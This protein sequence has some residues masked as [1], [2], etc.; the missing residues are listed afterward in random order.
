MLAYAETIKPFQSRV[1]H[2]SALF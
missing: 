1:R 2:F